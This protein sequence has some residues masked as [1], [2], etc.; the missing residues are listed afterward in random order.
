MKV[1]PEDFKIPAEDIFRNDRLKRSAPIK[2]LT[3]IFE[4]TLE[5]FVLCVD[6][7]YGQGKT[8]FVQLWRAYLS[9]RGINSI[10]FNAWENDYTDSPLACL[11]AE[12]KTSLDARLKSV[13]PKSRNEIKKQ[14]KK[15]LEIG[16]KVVKAALP[17]VVKIA[18]AGVLKLDD[19]KEDVIA[20]FLEKTTQTAIEEYSRNKDLLNDF[21]KTL[22]ENVKLVSNNHQ[23]FIFVDELDRCRPNFAIEVLETIKHLFSIDG[24]VFVLAL[25]EAQLKTCIEH[26]YGTQTNSCGYL[27]RFID[28]TYILP[29]PDI[30]DYCRE[31]FQRFDLV[32][33]FTK[34]ED[35]R[36][37]VEFE[38]FKHIEANAIDLIKHFKLTLREIEK[39]FTSFVLVLKSIENDDC[40]FPDI[41]FLLLLIRLRNPLI[42]KMII[43]KKLKMSDILIYLT[44]EMTISE[45]EILI[46]DNSVLF[47]SLAW[48]NLTLNE[49]RNESSWKYFYDEIDKKYPNNSQ[50]QRVTE[51]S[52]RYSERINFHWPFGKMLDLMDER[53]AFLKDIKELV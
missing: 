2:N 51:W 12:I 53:I 39:I 31:M 44:K 30:T 40:L 13:P 22:Q 4:N 47:I 8:T 24:V 43:E 33:Y 52:R 26:V 32:D 19:F 28:T 36:N 15:F 11:I 34:R 42:Y 46:G 29:S 49:S 37:L 9:S 1:K 10:L 45:N 7:P 17:A 41:L 6:A 3:T 16:G 21:K 38:K 25:D 35:G 27:R 50:I 48:L 18:T 5:P 23:F 20:E 14:S